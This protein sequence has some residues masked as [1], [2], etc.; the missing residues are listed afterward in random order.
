MRS[1]LVGK[2]EERVY[3]EYPFLG[4]NESGVVIMFSKAGTGVIVH[5]PKYPDSVGNHQS[6]VVQDK[7]EPLRGTI[8]LSN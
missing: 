4:I 3:Q 8:T 6:N 2:P 5:S 7:F 1:D